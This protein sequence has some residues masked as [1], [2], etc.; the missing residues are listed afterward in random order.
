MTMYGD[1]KDVKELKASY[2]QDSTV[3]PWFKAAIEAAEN[4][5]VDAVLNE[6]EEL[7]NLLSDMYAAKNPSV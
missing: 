2:A 5:D 4:G 3:S 1:T 7:V 6:A